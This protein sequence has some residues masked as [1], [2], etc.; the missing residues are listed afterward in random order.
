MGQIIEIL[1]VLGVLKRHR[2]VSFTGFVPHYSLREI[3]G[4][5]ALYKVEAYLSASDGPEAASSCFIPVPIVLVGRTNEDASP[6][7]VH[8]VTSVAGPVAIRRA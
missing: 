3:L 7:M 8:G 4:A 2:P 1:L 6:G 5:I